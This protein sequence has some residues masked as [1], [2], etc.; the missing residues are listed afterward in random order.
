MFSL[1]EEKN[2]IISISNKRIRNYKPKMKIKNKKANILIISSLIIISIFAF[3]YILIRSRRKTNPGL[4]PIKFYANSN[5]IIEEEKPFSLN[6]K[7]EG[8]LSEH[9]YDVFVSAI[10]YEKELKNDSYAIFKSYDSKPKLD[11]SKKIILTDEI[12]DYLTD[13]SEKK[14]YVLISF[15]APK[16]EMTM[17]DKT[18]LKIKESYQKLLKEIVKDNSND[19]KEKFKNI[20]DQIGLYVPNGIIYGGRIDLTFEMNAKYNVNN[21]MVIKDEIFKSSSNTKSLITSIEMFDNYECNVIGGGIKTFCEDKD[22]KK[23]YD[24]LSNENSEIILYNNL[25]T[26][27]DYLDEDIEKTFKDLFCKNVIEYPDGIYHGDINNNKR[28]GYGEFKYNN[29]YLYLGEWKD[30]KREGDYGILFNEKNIKIYNG[31]WKNDAYEGNGILYSSENKL[32]TFEEV[33]KTMNSSL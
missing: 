11:I 23:W 3:F 10:K 13:D 6:I 28:N 24:S 8:L 15:V 1:E 18:K 19:K 17:T 9:I 14:N 16:I 30:D 7:N 2:K 31:R 21:I 25:E 27:S 32:T 29:D 26:I 33:N 12:A 20:I 5:I 22:L 4:K